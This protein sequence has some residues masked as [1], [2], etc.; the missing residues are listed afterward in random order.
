MRDNQALLAQNMGY[1][2]SGDDRHVRHLPTNDRND[3]SRY[4]FGR[5]LMIELF[6]HYR[7]VERPNLIEMCNRAGLE[8][9]MRPMDARIAGWIDA[10]RSILHVNSHTSP[11][12]RRFTLAHQASHWLWHLKIINEGGGLNDGMDYRQILGGPGF[13]PFI[14]QKQETEANNGAV[15]LIMPAEIVRRLWNSG[16]DSDQIADRLE[17]SREGMRIRTRPLRTPCAQ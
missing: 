4:G 3:R 10:E 9:S 14:T 6:G 8:V 2:D 1:T 11:T 5:P 13:N 16:L 17:I 15:D 12:R 7:T